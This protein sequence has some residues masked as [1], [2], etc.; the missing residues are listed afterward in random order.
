MIAQK[1]PECRDAKERRTAVAALLSAGVPARVAAEQADKELPKAGETMVVT[2]TAMK[3]EVPMAETP[4]PSPWSIAKSWTSTPYS[5]LDESLRYRSGVLPVLWFRTRMLTGSR[6]GLRCGFLPG[7]QPPVQ[8]RLLCLD[9]GTLRP[10]ERGTAQRPG[11]HSVRR[12]P[13]G[14]VINAISK[15][16][17]ATP[18]G[19]VNLQLG[20]RDLR[21]VGV[22]VSDSLTDNSRYRLV[23]LYNERDG[24]LDGTYNERAYLAPSVTLDISDRT[25][26][27]LL[28]S[29]KHDEGVPTNGFFPVYGT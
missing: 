4:V 28:S 7:W 1:Y 10:G 15:R 27:T 22:D 21:Q 11:L 8:H 24:V 26:L 12:S 20:N 18:Q 2:G 17:T 29:F 3:V 9:P 19:L 13:P 14:G 25:T 6:C 16:P 23:A 5:K